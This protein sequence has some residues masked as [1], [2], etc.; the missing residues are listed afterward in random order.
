MSA[1]YVFANPT[2]QEIWNAWH[3]ELVAAPA[4]TLHLFDVD[5]TPADGDDETDYSEASFPGYAPITL[6]MANFDTPT[7]ASFIA[8]IEYTP[9][10]QFDYTAGA[11]APVTIYGYYLLDD[12]DLFRFAER[13]V[14]PKTIDQG[15]S[16][17]VN[18]RLREKTCR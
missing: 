10:P 11:S 2:L 4:W 13:V 16:L 15:E 3:A 12:A 5:H 8:E 17:K 7:V 9:A 14:T 6:T 18:I 1:G